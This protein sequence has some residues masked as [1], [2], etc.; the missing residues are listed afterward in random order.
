MS[1][2]EYFLNK[3]GKVTLEV[4]NY[5]GGLVTILVSENQETGIHKIDWRAAGVSDGI[6]FVRLSQN[7]KEKTIKIAIKK[8]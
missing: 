8:I 3:S 2:F 6:Y 1:I 7:Q 4:F 5:T